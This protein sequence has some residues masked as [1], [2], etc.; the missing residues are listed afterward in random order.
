M[1]N[2]LQ[3]KPFTKDGILYTIKFRV[4]DSVDSGKATFDLIY[5]DGDIVG[6]PKQPDN[7]PNN[8]AIKTT[9]GKVTL[10]GY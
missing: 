8:L 7:Q 3:L 6:E 10:S 1:T 5:R 4:K 9:G 2:G